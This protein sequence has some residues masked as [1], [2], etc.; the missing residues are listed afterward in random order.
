MKTIQSLSALAIMLFPLSLHAAQL[1]KSSPNNDNRANAELF[2]E[3]VENFYPECNTAMEELSKKT[4]IPFF[5]LSGA[6]KSTT[7]NAFIGHKMERISDEFGDPIIQI[8]QKSPGFP[9]A[10]IGHSTKSETTLPKIFMGQPGSGLSFLDCPGFNDSRGIEQDMFNIL[11]VRSFL[12][13]SQGVPAIICVLEHDSFKGNR[14]QGFLDTVKLFD[15]VLELGTHSSNIF[16]LCNKAPEK[17]TKEILIKRIEKQ[18]RDNSK[19]KITN[20]LLTKVLEHPENIFLIDPANEKSCQNVLN[21]LQK[22]KKKIPKSAFQTTRLGA[23]NVASEVLKLFENET[24]VEDYNIVN[25]LTKGKD[26]IKRLKKE[27]EE[28]HE[29]AEETNM[30][31]EEPRSIEGRFFSQSCSISYSEPNYPFDED[32]LKKTKECF[33][34]EKKEEEM[35]GSKGLYN[36]E[37]IFPGGW[38]FF[39]NKKAS[40][41]VQF[42]VKNKHIQKKLL[43]ATEASLYAL[44]GG[45]TKEEITKKEE[46]INEKETRLEFIYNTQTFLPAQKVETLVSK[47]VKVYSPSVSTQDEEK[48]NDE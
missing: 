1:P 30:F 14:G 48:K 32:L 29:N 21:S 43:E 7:I 16:W 19:N 13:A 28:M 34:L 15:N 26:E 20:N 2:W 6:G 36:A 41:V 8:A 40:I 5:G 37:Y 39:K 45:L 12:D 17:E 35:D 31:R 33:G 47:F 4:V 44:D 25:A 11:V 38:N 23:V 27:I 18:K 9:V 46:N 22:L 42:H 3:I 10:G 24:A